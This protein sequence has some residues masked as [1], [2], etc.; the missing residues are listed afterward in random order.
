V[1]AFSADDVRRCGALTPRERECMR[2]VHG[3]YSSKEIARL[4]RL[5]QT[6]VDTYV[7]RA[8]YKLGVSSRY[9]GAELVGLWEEHRDG[10]LAPL[11]DAQI[12]ARHLRG[13]PRLPAVSSLN[14]LERLGVILA[15]AIIGAL[16]FGILLTVLAHL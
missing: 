4:L 14:V 1:T 3:H 9:A 13:W 7:Q 15:G 6:S 11:P 10:D 16:G 5:S 8:M 12:A 2:L